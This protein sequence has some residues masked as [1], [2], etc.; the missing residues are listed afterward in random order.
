MALRNWIMIF[1]LLISLNIIGCMKP[2]DKKHSYN[3]VV[4]VMDR[5][6]TYAK[7]L[8][9]ALNKAIQLLD[10]MA[11]RKIH[12]WEKA[13]DRI[14]I[15]SLDA[16][17]EVIWEGTVKDLKALDNAAWKSRLLSRADYQ[18]CT[19][20]I[21]AF[22]LA[23]TKLEGDPRYINKYLFVF[24]DLIHEPP[25]N[26]IGRCKLPGKLPPD[27]FPWE[28]LRDVS[29]SVF[30]I[31]PEQKLLWKRAAM[32]SDSGENFAFYTT[33]E[34]SRIEIT[35]P[36]KKSRTITGSEQKEAQGTA[37]ELGKIL[38]IMLVV[39][40]F[41][42]TSIVLGIAGIGYIRRRRIRRQVNQRN[43][44]SRTA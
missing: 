41:L 36:P 2:N 6:G 35:P 29:V 39:F 23:A 4:I 33:S 15:I 40:I 11:K 26:S 25:G 24:S 8:E 44:V 42:S 32:E 3:R 7:R 27:E 19:D 21:A 22:K 1:S 17:P 28:T 31:P 43:D 30:W 12:R 18:N 14:T 37:I 10:E 20:V 16:M 9:E 34:S 5:S 38:V 13:S